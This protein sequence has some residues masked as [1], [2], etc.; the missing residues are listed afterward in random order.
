[1]AEVIPIEKEELRTKLL[2]V[3]KTTNPQE[4]EQMLSRA[5]VNDPRLSIK[6]RRG[7][8]RTTVSANAAFHASKASGSLELGKK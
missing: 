6:T 4:Y 8:V 2:K 5:M 7:T 1:M 3:Y